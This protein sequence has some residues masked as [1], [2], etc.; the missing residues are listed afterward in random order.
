MFERFTRDSR[1]VVEVA[2]LAASRLGA[3][4]VEPEHVLLALARGCEDPAARALAEVGVDGEAI[5]RAIEDDLVAM[6]EVVGVPPSVVAA[7]P[8]QPRHDRPNLS[9]VTKQALERALHEALRRRDRRLGTQHLLLGVLRPPAAT[10]R[11][12][13]LRL[14]VEPERLAA[15]VQVEAA[16][17][18]R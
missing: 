2:Q 13:L 12:V 4:H 7:T 6:L 1:R 10:V 18:R 3:E 15:L 5:A 17:A 16:A 8:P 11:R 14:D 9:P